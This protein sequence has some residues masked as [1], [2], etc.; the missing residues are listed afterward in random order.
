MITTRNRIPI[1]LRADTLLVTN[2]MNN[3]RHGPHP[4]GPIPPKPASPRA[5]VKLTKRELWMLAHAKGKVLGSR[6]NRRN[7]SV[8]ENSLAAEVYASPPPPLHALFPFCGHTPGACLHLAGTSTSCGAWRI[9][10]PTAPYSGAR[11]TP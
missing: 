6:R 10:V 8:D 7:P 1:D 3:A 9:T 2:W 4:L 11:F 5:K